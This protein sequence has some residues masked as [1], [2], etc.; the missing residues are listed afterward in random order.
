MENT[1][2][3]RRD[4]SWWTEEHTHAI[5]RLKK[6]LMEEPTYRKA[7]YSEGTPIYVTVDTSP[8]GIG[9]IV[10]QEDMQFGSTLKC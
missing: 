1:W 5:R 10:N 7:N 8:A 2:R 9:C 3:S 4:E 6:L